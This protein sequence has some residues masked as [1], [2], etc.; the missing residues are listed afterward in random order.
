[1]RTADHPRVLC[2][3]QA[4]INHLQDYHPNV[5]ASETVG[6]NALT[7]SAVRQRSS[8][9]T[10]VLGM[11]LSLLSHLLSVGATERSHHPG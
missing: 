3:V 2:T 9:L 8:A 7:P 6:K 1:M 4:K 10:V 11:F 5:G